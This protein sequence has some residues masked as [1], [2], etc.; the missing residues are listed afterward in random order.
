MALRPS[1]CCAAASTTALVTL[2]AVNLIELDGNELRREPIETRKAVL[3]KLLRKPLPGLVLN[4][5]FDEP[6]DVVFKHACALGCE[7][8]VSKRLGSRYRG[9]AVTEDRQTFTVCQLTLGGHQI[10]EPLAVFP[11][12]DQ[13]RAYVAARQTSVLGI[14][15]GKT[16]IWAPTPST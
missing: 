12:L 8:L 1:N 4:A 5:T 3:A 16:K 9:E 15:Q 6:G 7:G 14:Y 13:A 11:T 2:C 10:G